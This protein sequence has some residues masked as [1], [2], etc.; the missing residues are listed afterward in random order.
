VTQH[1]G[2]GCEERIQSS[3]VKQGLMSTLGATLVTV[4]PGRVEIALRPHQASRSSTASS[5]RER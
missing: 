3:F 5:M 2:T 4:A 1:E